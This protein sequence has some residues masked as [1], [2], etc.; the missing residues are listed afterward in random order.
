M[1]EDANQHREEGTDRRGR[2]GADSFAEADEGTNSIQHPKDLSL[3]SLSNT[4]SKCHAGISHVATTNLLRSASGGTSTQAPSW[5][6][7]TA[8]A[9]R[10]CRSPRPKNGTTMLSAPG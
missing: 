9:S 3:G 4:D 7:N 1:R 5:R 6:R 2:Y 10:P 8:Q